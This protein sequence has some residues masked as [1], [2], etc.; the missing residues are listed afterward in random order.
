[1]NLTLIWLFGLGFGTGIVGGF[2]G[3]G[4][5][6]I[7]TAVL[8]EWFK[9]QG[10]PVDTRFHLAFGTTL[11]AIFGTA[12]SSAFTYQQ[13][14]RVVWRAVA[15]MG[16]A[17]VIASLIGS[18][19]A[20]A[21][22]GPL[23]KTLFVSFCLFNAAMLF[24]KSSGL[25]VGVEPRLDITRLAMIG[26]LAGLMSAYLGIAGGV[27][28]VPLLILWIKIKPEMAPGTSSAVGVITSLVGAL[29]YAMN[30]TGAEHLP[31]G[32]WGFVV[33]AIAFPILLGTMAG[34]PIGSL[35]NRRYGKKSFRYAFAVFLLLMAARIYFKN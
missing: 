12:I 30:G 6:V 26:I 3:I 18:R 33:P 34:G 27:V 21:S 4:G 5:G 8:L 11:L 14:K 29:G 25:A 22:S 9:A 20:A 15:V 2:L 16:G 23:L 7:I 28:I 13:M 32:A 17:S 31:D 1:M 10:I 19:L 24:R 35:L